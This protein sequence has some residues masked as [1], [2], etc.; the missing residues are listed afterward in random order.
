MALSLR[1]STVAAS[2]PGNEEY[3]LQEPLK[4]DTVSV[5]QPGRLPKGAYTAYLL[6]RIV[7][8]KRVVAA[9]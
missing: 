7:I 3:S 8:C 9:E 5:Y 6:A 4:T 1:G 2:G